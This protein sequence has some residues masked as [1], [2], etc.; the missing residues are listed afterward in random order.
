MRELAPSTP[1]KS[2]VWRHLIRSPARR[3]DLRLFA[4]RGLGSAT[5]ITPKL[6]V[7]RLMTPIPARMDDTECCGKGHL[8]QLR[9]R[10]NPDNYCLAYL[11]VDAS[12]RRCHSPQTVARA[13]GEYRI[14]FTVAGVGVA[15]LLIYAHCPFCSQTTLAGLGGQSKNGEAQMKS[16]FSGRW[17]RCCW[18]AAPRSR[19]ALVLATHP[20]RQ[21]ETM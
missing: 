7:V 1:N 16:Y 9:V 5:G 13:A 11:T 18:P 10:E 17:W 8:F 12:M 20:D 21:A 4:C 19:R 14:I 6:R 15:S 3:P 2:K